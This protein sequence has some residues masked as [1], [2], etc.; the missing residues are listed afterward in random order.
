MQPRKNL[1]V[2]LVC[3]TGISGYSQDT[4][5][6]EWCLDKAS[7]NHPRIKNDE[8]LRNISQERIHNIRAGNLPKIELNGKLSYQSDAIS[9]DIDVPIPGLVFP[10]SP[11]DQYK[12]S[13]DITQSIYDGGLSGSRQAVEEINEQLD[14]TQLEMDLRTSRIMVK[15]LYYNVLLLQK[16][17]EILDVTLAQLDESRRFTVAGI[18]NGILMESDR[19]LVD[20]EI[21]RLLLKKSELV[22]ARESGIKVLSYR[23][24]ETINPETYIKPTGFDIPGDSFI[25]IRPEQKLFDLQSLQTQK[26]QLL[27]KS[28]ALPKLYAFGQFGYG[29]P[30][31][32]MLK[33]EFDTYY[34]VGACLNFTIWDWKINKRDR[35]ILTLQ[36]SLIESRKQQFEYDMHSALIQQ[37]SV[38]YTQLENLESYRQILDLRSR[39]SKTAKSQMESGILKTLDY[40]TIINQELI[41]RLQYENE[42]NALQQSI[43]RYYE[44]TGNL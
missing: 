15:D 10:E 25:L 17:I 33:D 13:L 34:V 23:T 37:K 40:L 38:I 5:S 39:I 21:A 28:R 36:N 43:A 35:N 3:I 1:F 6:L 12:I 8:L 32:N 2:L 19:D 26:S 24:G 44:L 29:N 4:V 14:Q 27:V 16:N 30:A 18:R 9:L 41:A 31:L 42:K 7:L 22:S 20:V 11:R